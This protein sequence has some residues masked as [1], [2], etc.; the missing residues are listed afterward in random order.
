MF[1]KMDFP[2]GISDFEFEN[3][4]QTCHFFI[5]ALKNCTYQITHSILT[6]ALDQNIIRGYFVEIAI[7]HHP[8]LRI[9]HWLFQLFCIQNVAHPNWGPEETSFSINLFNC[10]I[11][12]K[13]IHAKQVFCKSCKFLVPNSFLHALGHWVLKI[14]VIPW[15][16]D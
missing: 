8:I 9:C 13:H 10:Q 14:Q 11:C 1:L 7:F 4:T 15:H 16:A 12:T 3:R 2:C 6:A 5:G